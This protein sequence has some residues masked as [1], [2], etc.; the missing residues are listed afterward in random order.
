MACD[1]SASIPEAEAGGYL[2]SMPDWTGPHSNFQASQ[3]Y[4]KIKFL[5][6]VFFYEVNHC[7]GA[8]LDTLV[9]LVTSIFGRILGAESPSILTA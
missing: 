7:S 8:E 5:S 1:F 3:N 4:I 6:L 2:S 9:M